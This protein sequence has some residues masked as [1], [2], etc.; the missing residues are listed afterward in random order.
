MAHLRTEVHIDASPERV[1]EVLADFAAYPSW[2]P[3]I[4]RIEGTLAEGE[5]LVVRIEPPGGMGMTLRPTVLSATP[6]R[7]FRWLGHLLVPGLFDGEHSFQ[8]E[9]DGQ[10]VRLVHA[11]TFRG[12]LVPLFRRSLDGSVRAGFEAMNAA[13]KERAERAA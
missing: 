10:G 9:K 3:F 4:R 11:E 13:L 12:A 2:N 1:W 6:I 8:L 7:E 5:R